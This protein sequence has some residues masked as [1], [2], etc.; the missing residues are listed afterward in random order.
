M[1]DLKAIEVDCRFLDALSDA[2]VILDENLSILY[3]SSNAERILGISK[4]ELLLKNC[5]DIFG[6]SF[7]QNIRSGAIVSYRNGNIKRRI[8]INYI[9]KI[10]NFFIAILSPGP[11][12][13][14]E[15]LFLG[16][17]GVSK[18]MKQIFEMIKVVANSSSPVLITGETGTGK[19]MVAEAIHNL[20]GRT[21][22]IVKV[23]CSAFPE[24]LL[25]SE[26]FGYVR[27]AFTGADRNKPGKFEMANNG[28]LFLDEIG[29]L[30]LNLQ[31]KILRAVE[32]GEIEKLGDNKTT[33]V[34]TRVIC[35]TN[36]NI[37]KEVQE[38]RF[39]SDLYFRISVFRIHLPPLRERK[40]DIIPLSEY[41]LEKLSQKY[42]LGQKYLTKTAI[43]LILSWDFPGNIRELENLLERAYVMSKGETINEDVIAEHKFLLSKTY[44]RNTGNSISEKDRIL[45]A[46]RKT[47]SVKEA[48]EILGIS[49]ITLWRKMKK[50]GIDFRRLAKSSMY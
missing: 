20:S 5:R 14:Q 35:A 49:R 44:E 17:V 9:S 30:P 32:R 24:T 41:I 2:V 27:G 6:K 22:Q 13:E 37:E 36:K 46:I 26:L 10:D 15:D 16:M 1:S 31:P 50:Y 12:Y 7:S 25:E 8:K 3:V 38:G 19:E 42:G 48:A 34:N 21:G 28:T 43:E 45:E 4:N 11:T 40:E 39:R 23:N 33:Y 29:D 47:N 18:S